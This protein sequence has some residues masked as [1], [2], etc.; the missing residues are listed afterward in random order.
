M[1]IGENRR[2]NTSFEPGKI[3]DRPFLV[4]ERIYLRPLELEDVNDRY[5]QWVN[6]PEVVLGQIEN[7]LCLL[8]FVFRLF[9]S[10]N[11]MSELMSWADIAISAGGSTCWEL[12]YMG[13]PRSVSEYL[14]YP[15][16]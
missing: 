3:L 9:S 7:E 2:M 5:L 11:N 8:P 15:I 12:A 10:V 4:G 1:L 14:L 6:D 16:F 13:L